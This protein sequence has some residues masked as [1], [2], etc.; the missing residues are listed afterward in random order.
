MDVDVKQTLR[1]GKPP[2]KVSDVVV[3]KSC[4][5]HQLLTSNKLQLIIAHRN[6]QM[7]Q[8]ARPMSFITQFFSNSAE[9]VTVPPLTFNLRSQL[10]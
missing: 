1:A 6:R 10:L 2:R 3:A 8:L 7:D 9:T 4:I 5:I